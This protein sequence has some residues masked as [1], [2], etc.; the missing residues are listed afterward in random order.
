MSVT[1]DPGKYFKWIILVVCTGIL[2]VLFFLHPEESVLFPRC[3]LNAFT[4]LYCPG[5]G[6]QR[7]IHSFLHLQFGDAVS[8]NI[9][10]FPA[11]L[12]I[13]YHYVHDWLNRRFRWRLP[14]ILYMKHTPWIILAVVIVFW[15]MRNIPFEPFTWLSPG[16]MIR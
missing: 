13:L 3:P 5:C 6:S 12:L 1:G 2:I 15:I 4:G 14:N 8:Y 10:V 9:L 11:A 16:G 7:A